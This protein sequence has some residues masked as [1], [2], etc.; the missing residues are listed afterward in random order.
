MQTR[1]LLFK[2]L[3]VCVG[4]VFVITGMVARNDLIRL[5]S[6]NQVAVVDPIEQY[7]EHR[8]SGTSTYTA[9][10]HFKTESGAEVRK[11]QSFPGK[12]L[13]DF[14][15]NIPVKVIYDPRNPSIF[16]F[17]KEKTDWT[18]VWVGISLIVAALIFA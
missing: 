5:K 11:K 8:K 2:V 12:L 17:Q 15:S 6:M 18:S 16:A 14:K 9:E 10:F 13:E 4:L 7:T 1:S 3:G